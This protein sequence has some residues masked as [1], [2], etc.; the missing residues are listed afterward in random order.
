LAAQPGWPIDFAFV[1][2]RDAVIDLA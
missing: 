1:L 2:D